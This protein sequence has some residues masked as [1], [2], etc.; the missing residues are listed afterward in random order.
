MAAILNDSFTTYTLEYIAINRKKF[1][2]VTIIVALC[3]GSHLPISIN[4][5]LK[6]VRLK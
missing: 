3:G 6:V 5:R 1:Y 4:K 2:I